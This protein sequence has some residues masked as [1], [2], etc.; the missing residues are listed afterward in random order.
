M[1]KRDTFLEKTGRKKLIRDNGNH[2][3][4]LGIWQEKR[5]LS[6]KFPAIDLPLRG[7]GVVTDIN[8]SH[9]LETLRQGRNI[10]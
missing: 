4:W 3:S 10:N 8:Y 9:D 5:I 1:M 2:H 6:C 7:V